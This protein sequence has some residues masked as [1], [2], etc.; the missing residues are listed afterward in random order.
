MV[1]QNQ[2]LVEQKNTI[3]KKDRREGKGRVV[4]ISR[5]VYRLQNTDIFYVES[6]G[7]DNI[8]YFVKFKPDVFEWCSCLDNSTRRRGLKCKH[9]FAIEFAIRMGT[10]KDIDRL[11]ADAKRYPQ[12]HEVVT[13][14]LARPA[15]IPLPSSSGRTKS[16]R[17]D[18][19]DFW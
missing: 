13:A 3:E 2:Q 4:A 16:W 12:K 19:Y 10:I 6:E 14:V 1:K 15:E 8:Y 5:R 18:E 7:S 9:L 17:D 11:P